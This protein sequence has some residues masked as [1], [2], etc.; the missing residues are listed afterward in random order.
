LRKQH[1]HIEKVELTNT[2]TAIASNVH[3][4]EIMKYANVLLPFCSFATAVNG[5]SLSLQGKSSL[6]NEKVV[7]LEEEA[8]GTASC[9]TV[10]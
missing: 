2:L 5:M 10:M 8:A 1:L 9:A 3:N 4:Y 7:K 6:S